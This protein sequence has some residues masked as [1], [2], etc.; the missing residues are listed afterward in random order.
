MR[1][2]QFDPLAVAGVL[3]ADDLVGKRTFI[4]SDKRSLM[5]R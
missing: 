3:P 2:L 1:P 4:V 5:R